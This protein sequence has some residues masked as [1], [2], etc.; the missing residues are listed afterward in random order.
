MKIQ[1][2]TRTTLLQLLCGSIASQSTETDE[3]DLL[4]VYL[5]PIV[6]MGRQMYPLTIVTVAIIVILFLAFVITN[7]GASTASAS[8]ILIAD[9]SPAGKKKLEE[10]KKEI[11]TGPEM[12]RKFVAAAVKYSECPSKSKFGVLGRFHQARLL[13][14][15][16]I[17]LFISFL[18][19]IFLHL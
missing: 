4:P 19:Y 9:S 7:P 11:G 10:I 1:L 16:G 5:Q 13:H 18:K 3:N 17:N 15:A 2:Y 14:D 8:H 6:V 12:G